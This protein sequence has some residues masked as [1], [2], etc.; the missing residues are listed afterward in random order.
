MAVAVC[1]GY[2]L[3]DPAGG[4][5][6]LRTSWVL[7]SWLSRQRQLGRSADLDF[8]EL[9]AEISLLLVRIWTLKGESCPFLVRTGT[10]IHLLPYQT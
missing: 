1:K 9:P 7:G 10:N 5:G 8:R 6:N 4:P 3:W 2:S